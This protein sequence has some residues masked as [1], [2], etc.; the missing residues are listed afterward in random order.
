MIV[1]S[2][3]YWR[4][5]FLGC[6]WHLGNF[7]GHVMC[8]VLQ[9]AKQHSFLQRI[10]HRDDE[11]AEVLVVHRRAK[12]AMLVLVPLLL[13]PCNFLPSTLMLSRSFACLP[14]DLELLLDRESPLSGF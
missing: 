5:A 13:D 1:I 4:S 6:L 2:W 8:P 14:K 12:V 11:S 9:V 7:P 10:D 3:L